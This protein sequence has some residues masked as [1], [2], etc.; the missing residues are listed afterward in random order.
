MG[1]A[2]KFCRSSVFLCHL[3]FHSLA[4]RGAKYF[5]CP[6]KQRKI[7]DIFA[8]FLHFPISH[9]EFCLLLSRQKATFENQ[10][11][12]FQFYNSDNSAFCF[13]FLLSSPGIFFAR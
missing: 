7:P 6:Q 1:P 13:F 8:V 11:S 9:K 12:T 2:L 4:G 10:L 3:S 5:A